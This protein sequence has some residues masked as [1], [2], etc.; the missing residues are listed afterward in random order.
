VLVSK[1]SAGS[2]PLS[3]PTG[4]I[5]VAT[6]TLGS[7]VAMLTSTVVN[8]A[9]PTLAT[10]LGA[11]TAGQQ[12]IVNAYLLTLASLIL[13]GGSLGDRYG[14]LR[15][16]RLGVGLFAVASVA[17]ALAPTV[18][19]LIACRLA[20]GIGG[21]L[22]TPG[23]LAIIEATLRPADRGRGVGLWSGLGGIAGAIGPLL[24]GLLV[25]ISWRWVFVIN[26]PIAA[27]VLA[28][29]LWVPES[30]DPEALDHPIDGLGATLTTLSLGGL[31]FG[32]I[33]GSRDGFGPGSAVAIGFGVLAAVV[34]FVVEARRPRGII[35][36]DLFGEPAFVGANLV[37]V[38]VYAGLG[39][40]FLLLSVQL[41]VAAG[42]GAWAAGA[43][44][45]P[46]T[47]M[48][49]LFSSRAGDL[50]QR[51]GPR[52]PLTIGLLVMA[53][54]ML[55]MI[56]AD[57]EATFVADVLPAAVVFGLGLSMSVAP[58]TSAALSAAP[59]SRAGAASGFN[60]AVAR[61]G[62]LLA[63]A[64]IP[65][66]AG[67]GGDAMSDP[68]AMA[69]AYPVAVGIAASLVA[70]GALVSA[71]LLPSNVR[72]TRSSPKF[73]CPLDGPGASS[74]AELPMG[75]RQPRSGSAPRR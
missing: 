2:I 69:A 55:L 42:W 30:R 52:W 33:E 68:A 32:L 34:L 65:P 31:S 50:A 51:I 48:M 10:D 57:Q 37:T 46:V 54:G 63:V 17:C 38:L 62:Q 39:V 56:R 28:M 11:S 71:V 66:L 60:N 24:G 13:V 29:S 36:V 1:L 47:V 22:L 35:P 44:L 3:T 64:A 5:V 7:A 19:V 16:Y 72:R 26:V 49:L 15:V 25:E 27:V 21:A 12:W 59:E 41:Q 43:S 40:V 45:L 23:S 70:S 9:L 4:R 14:R 18:E 73:Q 67:L 61:T 6:T 53:G 20:Q 8:V 75:Q 74:A 58:V